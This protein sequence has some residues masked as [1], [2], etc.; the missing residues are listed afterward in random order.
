ML[1]CMDCSRPFDL[2]ESP[3]LGTCLICGGFLIGSEEERIKGNN[4]EL[5]ELFTKSLSYL[6][7]NK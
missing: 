2:D 1:Y 3:D 4:N 5:L 6:R 7:R